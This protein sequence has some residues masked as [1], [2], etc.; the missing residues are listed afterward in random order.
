MSKREPIKI[1]RDEGY[2]HGGRA[3]VILTQLQFVSTWEK[4]QKMDMWYQN[5]KCLAYIQINYASNEP[6]DWTV[7][8]EQ[9]QQPPNTIITGIRASNWLTPKFRRSLGQSRLHRSSR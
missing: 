7:F 1:V 9:G 6:I 5:P 4:P 8:E 2:T 3:E